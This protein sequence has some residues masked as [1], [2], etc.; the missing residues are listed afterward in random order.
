[1]SITADCGAIRK[2]Q[3]QELSDQIQFVVTLMAFKLEVA[4]ANLVD[5]HV[6]VVLPSAG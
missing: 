5:G 2:I 1:M 4:A 3:V 6:V